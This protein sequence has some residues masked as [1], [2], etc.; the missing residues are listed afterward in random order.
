MKR[1]RITDI[2]VSDAYGANK[3]SVVGL[4]GRGRLGPS[5]SCGQPYLSG[6]FISDFTVVLREADGTVFATDE[7]FFAGIIAEEI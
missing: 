3:V 5:A 7:F 6:D 1:Y 4:T 2:A